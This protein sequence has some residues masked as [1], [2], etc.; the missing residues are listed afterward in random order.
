[1]LGG[2][3]TRRARRRGE[4]DGAS[5]AAGSLRDPGRHS[6]GLGGRAVG[7]Q[8]TPPPRPDGGDSRGRPA[9]AIAA[10]VFVAPTSCGR[11]L[12][13]GARQKGAPG[14]VAQTIERVVHGAGPGGARPREQVGAK[15]G[16]TLPRASP[17]PREHALA[18]TIS[19][20]SG[21]FWVRGTDGCSPLPRA[22]PGPSNW[23]QAWSNNPLER[24]TSPRG[25]Q[26]PH[27]R[28]G[29]LPQQEARDA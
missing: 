12:G 7:H 10:V 5:R 8:A 19:A 9:G 21:L 2:L 25:F 11:L 13:A 16:P 15:V 4:E 18:G 28:G 1:M 27:R 17:G 22:F 29:Y 14:V 20:G 6:G 3:G 23:R 24:G 26:A